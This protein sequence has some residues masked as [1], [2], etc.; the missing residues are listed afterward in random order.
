MLSFFKKLLQSLIT[1]WGVS[2]VIF[3]LLFWVPRIGNEDP[4]NAIA[5]V[6]AGDHADEAN[7][8]NIKAKFGLDKPLVFQYSNFI[9]ASLTNNLRSYRNQDR[10][11][12]AIGRRFPA[13]LL[14]AVTALTLYLAV[15]I[16][17][18]LVTSHRPGGWL[19]KTGLFISIIAI[20]IPTF[21]LGRLLQN[22]LGYEWGWFS[23]GG[24]ANVWNL[25]LPAM[26]LGFGGAAYY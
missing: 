7:I 13:T 18:S 4:T 25:P 5:Q 10:V 24:G 23:V 1:L 3:L 22:Y 9:T 19:D 16:P 20:S 8:A 11:F 14:L 15:A 21:W 12:S 17:V 2:V 26:T 6:I